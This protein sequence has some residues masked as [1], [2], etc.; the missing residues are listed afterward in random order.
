MNKESITDRGV[1]C[2]CSTYQSHR[3]PDNI[4][5]DAKARVQTA[6]R[7]LLDTMWENKEPSL[8]LENKPTRRLFAAKDYPAGTLIL[9]PYTENLKV[10][11]IT[12]SN[13][14][15]MVMT[16]VTA[17]GNKMIWLSKPTIV[18]PNQMQ[19]A[20][21]GAISLFWCVADA[22]DSAKQP[23]PPANINMNLVNHCVRGAISVRPEGGIKALKD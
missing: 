21:K 10:D 20:G 4:D 18:I 9:I 5:R 3:K 17:S 6:L 19:S 2:D 22:A 8:R 7:I 23:T 13:K 15:T 12:D 1:L 16:D 14:A 11:K